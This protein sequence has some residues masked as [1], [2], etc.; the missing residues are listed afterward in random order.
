MRLVQDPSRF[1]VILME[2]LYGDVVS[3]LA[4]GLVGGLGVAPGANF[5]LGG[6]YPDITAPRSDGLSVRFTDNLAPFA[7]V[8]LGACLGYDGP[9]TWYQPTPTGFQGIWGASYIGNGSNTISLLV[10]FLQNGVRELTVAMPGT[11]PPALVG[12]TLAFQGFVWDINTDVADWSNAQ[13]VRF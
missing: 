6:I 3:D 9:Y 4:A 5:G 8:G 7:L 2:N 10:S 1:D 12:T 13:A 11:I